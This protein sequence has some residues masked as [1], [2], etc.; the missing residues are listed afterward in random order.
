MKVKLIKISQLGESRT[1]LDF[2]S[3][4]SNVWQGRFQERFEC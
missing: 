4:R 3:L 2:E 1:W